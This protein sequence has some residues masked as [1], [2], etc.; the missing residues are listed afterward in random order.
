MK[1]LPILTVGITAERWRRADG[2][3]WGYTDQAAW[4]DHSEHCSKDSQSPIDITGATVK[5]LGDFE[6]NQH[7]Y[8]KEYTWAGINNGHTIKFTPQGDDLPKIDAQTLLEGEYHLGQFH[9]HWGSAEDKGSE[10]TV[11]GK[12]YFAEV[13]LVHFKAEYEGIGGSLAHPGG[14]AVVG[15]FLEVVDTEEEGPMD[16]FLQDMVGDN[17]L[18]TKAESEFSVDFNLKDLGLANFTDYYRYS[19]SLTT[20]P[21][22]E[23][24]QWTVVRDT[25]KIN[26]E[27]MEK[28]VTFSKNKV[29]EMVIDNYRE[30]QALND[31]EIKLYSSIE[32]ELPVEDEN[33]V[34]TE[35]AHHDHEEEEDHDHD[36][37]EAEP[38]S[39]PEV[40][41]EA[42]PEP[43][44][45][46]NA[47]SVTSCSLL[48]A[49]LLSL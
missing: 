10:H 9:F 18:E 5:K 49:Y 34:T 40:K 23:V 20:P 27:T 47:L 28:M 14:L 43:E 8:G 29:G 24:V 6:F 41:S 1:I 36:E 17:L 35:K 45:E 39:E 31:R 37:T 46:S 21:C 38:E 7:H 15:H 19:G 42:E 11:D 26:K 44:G 2:S 32:S 22:N 48:A 33:E 12:R 30:I 16:K 3:A 25:L 4:S 13:H